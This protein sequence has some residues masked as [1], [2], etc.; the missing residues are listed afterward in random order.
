[1]HV[2]GS[3]IGSETH[4]RISPWSS[5]I[6]GSLATA[7]RHLAPELIPL[8]RQE[9]MKKLRAILSSLCELKRIDN[10]RLET[11]RE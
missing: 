9:E 4:S 6:P 1:M 5:A 11:K 10:L 7:K 8:H 3:Q 2:M